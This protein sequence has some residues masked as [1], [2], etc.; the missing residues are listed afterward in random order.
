M[1]WI[2][3]LGS[4]EWRRPLLKASK[5]PDDGW[6]WFHH[7]NQG[8]SMIHSNDPRHRKFV[9]LV[10]P[11]AFG[12]GLGNGSAFCPCFVWCLSLSNVPRWHKMWMTHCETKTCFAPLSSLEHQYFFSL[13]HALLQ[14]LGKN[15]K[16]MA[17]QSSW[18]ASI[19]KLESLSWGFRSSILWWGMSITR[20]NVFR[21][22]GNL[23][24]QF[25]WL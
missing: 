6:D 5:V 7:I 23:E 1:L 13:W 12:C 20:T 18:V 24:K 9:P 14:P 17:L 8:I 3:W 25:K 22:R 21:M 4:I 19:L 10:A 2:S 15:W 16:I 11:A